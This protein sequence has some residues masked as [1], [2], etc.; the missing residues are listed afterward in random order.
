MG[1]N[2]RLDEQAMSDPNKRQ[3]APAVV[4]GRTQTGEWI[5]RILRRVIA[6]EEGA[7]GGSLDPNAPAPT[8]YTTGNLPLAD[9]EKIG[10]WSVGQ[11]LPSLGDLKVQKDYNQWVYGSMANDSSRIDLLI[12]SSKEWANESW[13]QSWVAQYYAPLDHKHPELAVDL[14]GYATEIWVTEQIAA[15]EHPED[16]GSSGDVDLTGYATEAWVNNQDFLSAAE[17]GTEM[18]P[19]A[20]KDWVEDN[21]AAFDHTHSDG[22]GTDPSL[23]YALVVGE[24]DSNTLPKSASDGVATTQILETITLQDASGNSLGDIHF[25]SGYGIGVAMST[26]HANTIFIQGGALQNDITAN[27]KKIA[28]LE[29]QVKALEDAPPPQAVIDWDS[30]PELQ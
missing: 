18:E 2:S 23:P 12:E 10:D 4:S 5:N 16:G 17:L 30:L 24:I 6:L 25:E 15:I 29:A 27:A 22:G 28:E 13:V 8:K 14:N 9:A 7:G 20:D 11:A 19:Y 26:R 1:V 21:F 3:V